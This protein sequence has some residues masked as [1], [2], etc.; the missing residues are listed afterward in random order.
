LTLLGLVDAK[1]APIQSFAVHTFD[2]LGGL[3]GG[4]HRHEREAA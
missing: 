2:G 1:R 3:F 4:A